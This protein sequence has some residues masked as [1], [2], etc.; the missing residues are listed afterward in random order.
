MRMEITLPTVDSVNRFCSAASKYPNDID[1]MYR[2]Y[3][4]DGKS[5]LGIQSI[6]RNEKLSVRVHDVNPG[7][8]ATVDIIDSFKEFLA[9]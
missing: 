6:P 7:D 4:L 8:K 9:K 3:I 5:V 1:V 2:H